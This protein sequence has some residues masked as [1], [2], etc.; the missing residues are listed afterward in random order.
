MA[1]RSLRSHP[2]GSPHCWDVPGHPLQ[3]IDA[4]IDAIADIVTLREID[5]ATSHTAVIADGLD[6]RAA[7]ELGR[8]LLG[9]LAG[10]VHTDARLSA[11][12]MVRGTTGLADVR[13]SIS[14][15]VGDSNDFGSDAEIRFRDQTRNAWIGE[16]L[17]HAMLVIR[18]RRDTAC[19][20]GPVIAISAPHTVPSQTG[21]DAVGVYDV[22]GEPFLAIGE[23]KA[24]RERG[25]QEWRKAAR[26]FARVDDQHYSQELRTAL[27][28]LDPVIPDHLAPRV[29][30]A[31]VRDGP[32]Y[33]PVI[34]HGDPFEHVEHRSWMAS[35]R[36][37]VGRRRVLVMPL[38]GFQAFFDVVANTMRAEVGAVVL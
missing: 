14:R 35:L 17:A 2:L 5:G 4:A 32:C 9:V 12:Y 21:I 20:A 18:N 31:I 30:E 27:I 25:A 37:P 28:A 22:G 36:P 24:T 29:G 6:E 34:V 1:P 8:Y 19:V 26:F 23:S 33:L 15:V 16:G 7:A 13:A 3:F 11:K 38:T 10:A